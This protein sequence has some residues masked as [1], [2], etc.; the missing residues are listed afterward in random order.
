MASK[1][2]EFGGS[3]IRVLSETQIWAHKHLI[4]IVLVLF[5]S[6]LP[7]VSKEL[8]GWI[9]YLVGTPA[10]WI[11]AAVQGSPFQPDYLAYS[12]GLQILR[13]VHRVAGVMLVIVALIT[14]LVEVTRIKKWQIWPEGSLGEAIRNLVDY[15]VR[16][17]HVR[18]G[19]YNFGQKL[20]TWA[21]IVGVPWMVVT[22]TILWFRTLFSP[23]TV[24]IA[25]FLHL[26]GAALG[27]W[28]LIVHVYAAL[29]IPEHKPMVRAMFRTG[30]VSEEYLKEHHPLYYEK[31]K[32]EG[33]I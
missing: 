1:L 31:L 14:A 28:L 16:K 15:Y 13:I 33:E 24:S 6:G 21:V 27:G 8:F 29:G 18:F 26:I 32:K 25:H 9:A 7:L 5:I 23:E 11:I 30:T 12:V 17:R 22:G 19:K 3:E 20:Y 10:A 4:H 2:R